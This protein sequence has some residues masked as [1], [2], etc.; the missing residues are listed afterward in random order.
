MD[1]YVRPPMSVF[2]VDGHIDPVPHPLPVRKKTI[3]SG[4]WVIRLV[5]LMLTLLALCGAA[6]EIYI[7][8]KIQTKLEATQEMVNEKFGAQKMTHKQ[9]KRN[10]QPPP[11]A[12][13]T[14]TEITGLYPEKP[15]Q[16]ESH[17][18]LSFLHQ[19]EYLDGSILCNKTGLYFVYSKLQL[20]YSNCSLKSQSLFYSHQVYKKNVNIKE[21]TILMENKMKFC[22]NNRNSLWRGSSFLGGNIEIQQG[23]EV[24]VRMSQKQLIRVKDGTL[25]FFGL[26]MI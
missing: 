17:F 2:T 16:W 19:V 10:N 23:D 8:R 21:E 20:G 26:F 25:T 9:G 6:T 4:H 24:Y 12:H 3:F 5:L 1:T 22:D 15:L 13:V 18:G 14:G 7:L 11:S